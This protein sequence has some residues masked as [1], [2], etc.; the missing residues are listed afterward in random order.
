MAD[1]A[2]DFEQADSGRT[3]PRRHTLPK[4][5]ALAGSTSS[6]K[7]TLARRLSAIT[8]APHIELDALFHGPNWTPTSDFRERV[9]EATSGDAWITD[10][11]YAAARDLTWARADLIVWLDYD[12]PRIL[13][14]LTERTFRRRWK[15]EELWNGN[16]ESLRGHFFSKQSLYLWALQTHHR[17]RREYPRHFAAYPGVRVV[18]IRSP[19]QLE[20]WLAPVA[21]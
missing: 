18:R 7:T 4:R 12:L 17:H 2:T 19:Q 14:R 10:G 20:R 16:R 13:W 8:G 1:S 3:T 21:P 9:A 5:I 15:N 11:N 6:G